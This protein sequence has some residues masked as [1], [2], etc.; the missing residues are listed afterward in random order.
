MATSWQTI[1][2]LCVFL[3]S[4]GSFSGRCHQ[5]YSKNKGEQP[6]EWTSR[7][8]CSP[9]LSAPTRD[10]NKRET[11]T[12]GAG[13]TDSAHFWGRIMC[14]WR[15]REDDDDG[16][17]RTRFMRSGRQIEGYELVKEAEDGGLGK[18]GKHWNGQGFWN[19]GGTDYRFEEFTFSN[20]WNTPSFVNWRLWNLINATRGYEVDCSLYHR[21]P[22]L[23]FLVGGIQY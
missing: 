21:F 22:S 10:R 17:K 12:R 1:R 3:V 2:N 23:I 19:K 20:S 9:F 11:Q 13:Q 7:S 14:S 5:A 16:E 18:H 15:Q 4:F 8:V 6:E